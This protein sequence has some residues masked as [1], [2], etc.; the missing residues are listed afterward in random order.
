MNNAIFIGRNVAKVGA[1]KMRRARFGVWKVMAVDDCGLKGSPRAKGRC[2]RRNLQK[3][4]TSREF[5]VGLLVRCGLSR[6]ANFQE[7]E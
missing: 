6:T 4:E 2:R 5:L 3:C 7:M 1:R